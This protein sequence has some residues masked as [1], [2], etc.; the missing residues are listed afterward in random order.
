MVCGPDV[1]ASS[2]FYSFRLIQ[3][4]GE[5]MMDVGTRG[6]CWSDRERT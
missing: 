2:P 6:Q 1:F 4:N 5:S 3:A